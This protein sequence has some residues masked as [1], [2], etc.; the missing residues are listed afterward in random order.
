[1]GL[2]I[3]LTDCNGEFVERIDDPKNLLHELLPPADEESESVLAK[4]D[5]YG[6]TYFNHLQIGRFLREWDQLEQRVQSPEEKALIVGVRQL[7][8]RCRKDRALL[9]VIGD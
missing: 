8:L 5:W 1:M 9:R 2:N 6:D 7:A 3:V 4:I